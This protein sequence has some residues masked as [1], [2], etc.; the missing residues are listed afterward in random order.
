MP[1]ANETSGRTNW[2]AIN[3]QQAERIVRNLRQRIF[4]AS[5]EGDYRKVINLQ[6]LLLR[7]Q[8]NAQLSV[9]KVTQENAGKNTPGVDKL[10]VKTPKARAALVEEIMFHS[11]RRASPV[12]RVYIPKTNGKMRPLGI[13]TVI[14]RARQAI[15]KLRYPL[16]ECQRAYRKILAREGLARRFPLA[17]SAFV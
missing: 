16:K 7:S 5:R 17:V 11:V 10:V 3:W 1:K 6:K 2:T 14:D 4:R 8:A 12:R 13:P 9:R 15:V